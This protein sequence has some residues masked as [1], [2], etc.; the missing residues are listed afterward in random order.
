MDE[1]DHELAAAVDV[2]PSGEFRARVRERIARESMTPRWRLAAMPAMVSAGAMAAV[3]IAVVLW[4]EQPADRAPLHGTS[5]TDVT[6]AAVSVPAPPT[7]PRASRP[8]AIKTHV[9]PPV[10]PSEPEVLL[11]VSER[12]GFRLLLAAIADDRF[13]SPDDRVSAVPVVTP[14]IAAQ[15]EPIS[16]TPVSMFG[17]EAEG[18]NQ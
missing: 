4:P 7:G 13:K 17:A 1:L 2:E 12:D 8:P 14:V 16:I 18:E 10:R 9:S 6:L 5:G 3:V 11:S 15:V